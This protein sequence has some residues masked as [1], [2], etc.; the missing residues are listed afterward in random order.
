M[1]DVIVKGAI[2]AGAA[3]AAWWTLRPPRVQVD[4]FESLFAVPSDYGRWE[5]AP[6]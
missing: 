2:A 6:R 5:E 1:I 4:D 3:A